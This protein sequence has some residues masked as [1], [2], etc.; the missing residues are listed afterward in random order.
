MAKNFLGEHGTDT[1]SQQGK[2]EEGSFT[3]SAAVGTSEVFIEAEDQKRDQVK[4]KKD[5]ERNFHRIKG[6][7]QAL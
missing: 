3:D 4:Y 5:N 2:R 7:D 6:L 1:S